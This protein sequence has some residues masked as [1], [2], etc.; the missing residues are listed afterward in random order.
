MA[1][2]QADI[3]NS[4]F[5]LIQEHL[6]ELLATS[7][8]PPP[9][10]PMPLQICHFVARTASKA[11]RDDGN[12]L[13]AELLQAAVR[14]SEAASEEDAGHSNDFLR[15]ATGILMGEGE[16]KAKKL[17][18][19]LESI[20][21]GLSRRQWFAFEQPPS[22]ADGLALARSSEPCVT[23]HVGDTTVSLFF[24]YVLPTFWGTRP[25][26]GLD[27]VCHHC[28]RPIAQEP[29]VR[30]IAPV[31]PNLVTGPGAHVRVINRHF[32][33]LRASD[34]LWVPVSHVWHDS[35]RR[36]NESGRHDDEAAATMVGTLDALLDASVDAYVPEVEFW[37]DY[38]SVPQ[39]EPRT[40]ASLLLRIPS[41]YHEAKE[42]VV[43]MSDIP[44]AHV[45]MLLAHD[46]REFS[47]L[48]ALRFMHVL[49]VLCSSQWMQRMWVLLEYSFCRTACIM[50]KSGYIWRSPDQVMEA[51]RDTFTTFVE[52]GQ[53]VLIGLFR[54][55][56]S[57]ASYRKDC[58][59]A[60]VTEKNQGRRRDLCLGE[61]V[62]LIARTQCQ[63]FR[64]R[65]FAVHMLV[66]GNPPP[67][68]DAI[69]WGAT[70]ACRYVWKA[71]LERQD[72]SPL[73]LQPRE[74][75]PG[76]N[77]AA[78][79][80]SWLA[81][82]NG[83]DHAEWDLGNQHTPA[84]SLISVEG[85]RITA[86]LEVV[87][88][89]EKI[90]FLDVEESGEVKGVEWA[91]GIL[92]S[93]AGGAPGELSATELIDGLNRIFPSD[94]IHT[95]AAQLIAGVEYTMEGLQRRDRRLEA[96]VQQCLAEY[97]AG[98]LGSP[99]RRYAAQRLTRIMRYDT[100]I[101]G[102]TPAEVTRLTKS[103]HIA[104]SRRQ[105]GALGGEPIC[106]ARCVEPACQA[107]TVLRLDLRTDAEIGDT[108]YRVPG[109]SYSE[110]T[111]DG[112]KPLEGDDGQDTHPR[113]D[114]GRY[115]I[116][117]GLRPSWEPF[118]EVPWI[119]C[120]AATKEVAVEGAGDSGGGDSGASKWS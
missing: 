28:Q 78:E 56:K 26:T 82:Y 72:F 105:R 73:L 103:R 32:A 109:L 100:H 3:Q 54:H 12:V 106:E 119:V 83:L 41:I 114:G 120:E 13:A 75:N 116:L 67:A 48:T 94:V 35:I 55:A 71:A 49:H 69:P 108:V 58:F 85:D 104:R 33:C 34:V 88:R 61:A 62:E 22:P 111:E 4:M 20:L 47:P 24:H 80:P 38:F 77:P 11:L 6:G 42:I 23:V 81:G 99:Q 79:I 86:E 15:R 37:H 95:K 45:L 52:N 46:R 1:D 40:K 31:T 5:A 10:E 36:A 53:H 91:I 74:S 63:V 92:G 87:G 59:L 39:W 96:R 117:T 89:I 9:D 57:F 65:F 98:P 44:G 113:T 112:L 102:N 60:G 64:D 90:H 21:L 118:T 43:Q 30:T 93:L 14:L 29:P 101:M 16:G 25:D 115:F 17:E 76:S 27:T 2:D 18:A 19:Y 8:F 50:D 97:F 66:R 107:V 7:Q 84:Q 70:E 110:G 68:P 51:E